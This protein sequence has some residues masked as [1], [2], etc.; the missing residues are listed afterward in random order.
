MSRTPGRG[1]ADDG[2]R[3]RPRVAALVP[4][5]GR[6]ERLAASVP[7][8]MHLVAGEPMLVHSVRTL[9][10]SKVDLIVVAAPPALVLEVEQVLERCHQGAQLLVVA[11]GD[12]R[13]QS[14]R[15]ALAVLPDSVE[16]VLVHDAAR[17]LVPRVLVDSVV[18]AV[19]AGAEAVVPGLPMADT[20]KE[21]DAMGRVV[22]TLDREKLRLIQT[23]QG[24][25]RDL[26]DAANAGGASEGDATDDAGHVER[27]GKHVLVVQGSAE[28]FKV[29][30]PWDL[31]LAEAL[32]AQRHLVG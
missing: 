11:G 10:A 5:A 12:S 21:V 4:A 30:A 23:P 22:R 26:L 3:E 1:D 9:A 15:N 19:S 17:P 2:E 28:A 6:G 13:S 16:I 31:R 14:V 20:A 32:L 27:L 25:R 7:K 8:A 18:D 24:F 29:T